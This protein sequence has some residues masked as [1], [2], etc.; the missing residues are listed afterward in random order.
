MQQLDYQAVVVVQSAT[1]SAR[2]SK[3]VSERTRDEQLSRDGNATKR[4]RDG[5]VLITT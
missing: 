3:R 5:R 4:Q 2:V 1:N